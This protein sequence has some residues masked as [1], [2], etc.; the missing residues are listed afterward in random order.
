MKKVNIEELWIGEDF[1]CNNGERY[2]LIEL[3]GKEGEAIAV[4]FRY[5]EIGAMG[6][7]LVSFPYGTE[8]CYLKR[9]WKL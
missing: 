8:V 3:D 1:T 7:C 9:S 4:H 5:N 2:C 6:N